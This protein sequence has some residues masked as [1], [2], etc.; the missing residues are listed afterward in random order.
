[1]IMKKYL[2]GVL[3]LLL[4]FPVF[5][6]DG[7]GFTFDGVG[8]RI[9]SEKDKTVRTFEGG[10]YKGYY[11]G[12]RFEGNLVLPSVVKHN[13]EDYTLVEI[14]YNSFYQ[15]MQ[16]TGITLPNTIKTISEQAFY[17]CYAVT[18]ITIPGSV[19]EIGEK[20]FADIFCLEKINLE[21]GVG[22]IGRSAFEGARYV[23][24][25]VIPNSVTYLG[26]GA[27]YNCEMLKSVT[28]NAENCASDS[29]AAATPLLS[30][31]VTSVTIGD[32]VEVLPTGLCSGLELLTSCHIPP[33]VKSFGASVFKNCT[34]LVNVNLPDALTSISFETFYNCSSLKSINIPSSVTSIEAYAFSGSGCETLSLPENL[35]SIQNYAFHN[36]ENLSSIKIPDAVKVLHEGVFRDTKM[37]KSIVIP[38][39]VVEIKREAFANSGLESIV[40]P[41]TVQ[42]IKDKAF[43][44]CTNLKRLEYQSPQ[45]YIEDST[46][47]KCWNLKEVYLP[48]TLE[49]LMAY[50][51]FQC[52]NLEQIVIPNSVNKIQYASFHDCDLLQ[53]VIIGYGL[54]ELEYSNS[55]NPSKLFIT[56]ENPP[57]V[58]DDSFKNYDGDLYVLPNS[59]DSYLNNPIWS[60]FKSIQPMVEATSISVDRIEISGS[61]GDEIQLTATTFPESA[62][63]HNVFWT[64][65]N[66]EIAQVDYHGLVKFGSVAGECTICAESIYPG[67]SPVYIKVNG[68]GFDSVEMT[69]DNEAELPSDIYTIQ[70][71]LIK[72]NATQSDVE[73]LSPGL[74]IMKGRKILVR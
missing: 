53:T 69:V 37:L 34:S 73:N 49:T 50:S 9:I 8:Y 57:K 45:W 48:N 27:F 60:K 43:Y 3:F 29:Q 24:N 59:L 38:P 12:N 39:S 42:I 16:L 32:K 36:M 58:S 4:S 65:S 13:G 18:E 30:P 56:A 1:M 71:V 44:Y 2:Y 19:E 62:T 25:L 64:S 70:G 63:L 55:M 20:A 72:R 15:N 28:F 47:S 5:A 26:C 51:F 68:N 66:P 41:Y 17:N 22:A 67:V 14:G 7:D 31:S 10:A 33:S 61:E 35:R 74:Y 54:A 46:F 21:P 11:A 52:Y 6:K 23:E 40:I